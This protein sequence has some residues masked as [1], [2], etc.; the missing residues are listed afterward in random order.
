MALWTAAGN[1]SS[2]G[3]AL[4]PRDHLSF[5][6]SL[7]QIRSLVYWIQHA[8]SAIAVH[9]SPARFSVFSSFMLARVVVQCLRYLWD[10]M[11]VQGIDPDR[12]HQRL[13]RSHEAWKP[14][15]VGFETAVRACS[16]CQILT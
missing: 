12:R 10:E 2:P 13:S 8:A 4:A 15:R 6:T 14:C 9:H 16:K 3:M 5:P 1:E 11:R 7:I